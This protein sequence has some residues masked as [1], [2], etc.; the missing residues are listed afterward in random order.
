MNDNSTTELIGGWHLDKKLSVG[1]IV[2][3][4]VVAISV[5]IYAIRTEP[6]YVGRDIAGSLHWDGNIPSFKIGKAG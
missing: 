2:T 5:V 6:A 3:T 1:H 4:L